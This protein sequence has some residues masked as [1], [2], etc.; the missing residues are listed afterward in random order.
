M[1]LENV[2]KNLGELASR[3]AEKIKLAKAKLLANDTAQAAF[4]SSIEAALISLQKKENWKPGI[5][6]QDAMW[7]SIEAKETSIDIAADQAA[8]KISLADLVVSLE[9]LLLPPPRP[10]AANPVFNLQVLDRLRLISQQLD[11]RRAFFKKQGLNLDEE[12]YFIVLKDEQE[13][14]R[15][16]YRTALRFNEVQSTAA[17]LRVF[18]LTHKA[19]AAVADFTSLFKVYKGLTDNMRKRLPENALPP[20]AKPA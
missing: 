5:V 9:G 7:T 8:L 1:T 6:I 10:D 12:P 2:Q 14:V 20:P 17:D 4:L 19:M 18:E 3:C 13:P 11:E 16:R 15:T